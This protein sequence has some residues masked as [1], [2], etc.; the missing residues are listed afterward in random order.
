MSSSIKNAIIALLAGSLALSITLVV[1]AQQQRSV[2]VGVWQSTED[3]SVIYASLRF[4]E[5]EW[6]RPQRIE[7]NSTTE[8]GRYT[9]GFY[10]WYYE[11]PAEPETAPEDNGLRW[12][13]KLILPAF[14]LPAGLV[15]TFCDLTDA[16]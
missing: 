3:S 14:G 13:L 16:C 5:G 15:D 12:L 4:D 11:S 7:F 1:L 10:R 9:Y 8:S 6:A 2:D